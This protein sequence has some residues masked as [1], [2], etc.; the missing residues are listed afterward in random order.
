METLYNQYAEKG[1]VFIAVAVP[2]PPSHPEYHNVSIT[3][4]L[5][6]YNSSLTYVVDSKGTVASVYNVRFV[7]TLFVLSKSGPICGN[8]TGGAK[9]LEGLMPSIENNIDKALSEPEPA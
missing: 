5:S 6:Q 2:W 3:E 8:Y 7:P 4:F 9:D 1:V